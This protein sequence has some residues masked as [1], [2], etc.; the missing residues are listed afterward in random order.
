MKAITRKMRPILDELRTDLRQIY[1][2]RFKSLILYG[3]HARGEATNDSDI[4]VVVV[5][6]GL[7]NPARELSKLSGVVSRISLKYDTLI[8]LCPISPVD[9]EH[10]DSPLLL[11]VRREG[12]PL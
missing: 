3:S 12:V 11:N 4:D 5:I 1:G 8:S 7:R 6:E 10:R 9:F 2:E